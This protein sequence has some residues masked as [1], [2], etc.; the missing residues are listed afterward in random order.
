MTTYGTKS[1]R[2]KFQMFI[3]VAAGVTA[4]MVA[5]AS[6]G[7]NGGGGGGNAGGGGGNAG[8]GGGN[9]GVPG[10][11][12]LKTVRPPLPPELTAYVQNQTVLVALGKALFWD[13][14]TGG[15]GKQA[16]ASCHFHAGADHRMV[17]QL[18]N[19]NGPFTPN[20]SLSSFDFPFHRLSDMSNNASA[21][22]YDTAQRAGSAGL[23]RRKFVDVVPGFAADNGFDLSDDPTY[24][25]IGLDVRRVTGRN[26]PSVLNAAFNVRN[27]WDSRARNIFTVFT[28]FGDADTSGNIVID[29][30]GF[31]TKVRARTQN[32]SLASQSVGPPNNPTEMSLDGR[33]W[34]KLGKK[35]LSVHPLGK[36]HVSPQDSVLGFYSALGG[37]PGL[38]PVFTYAALIQSAFVSTYWSSNKVVDAFG[39]Y[40]GQ[41]SSPWSPTIS[42]TNSF[43]QMEYNFAL[44]WGLAVQAYEAT[45]IT[46]N[47]PYDQYAGGN[48]A[49]MTPQQVAGLN[50]FTGKGGCI[51]CHSGPEFTSA[52][53]TTVNKVGTTERV[54]GKLTDTGYFRTGVRP[55]AE[56]IGIGGLDGFGLPLSISAAQFPTTPLAVNGAFK[57]PTVR[58][59]E[60]TGPYMHNGG[61]ATL[62]QVVDFYNRGGDFPADGNLGPGIQPLHLGATDHAALVAFMT[63]LS[64]DRAR[65]ER[66]PFDHPELCVA[67]GAM[68]PLQADTSDPR[69]IMDAKDNMVG[70][71]AV[72]SAGNAVPLQTFQ[73]LLS[74]IGND[75][76]RAHTLKDVCSIR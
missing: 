18:S 37:A 54:N 45:L 13:M 27:F 68:N 42:D 69:F 65:Y 76:S 20:Y 29:Q 17:D 43:T 30:G 67:N 48:T 31:M 56:D 24:N 34:Q 63:A 6:G 3:L 4:A 19:G 10:L 62:D 5:L 1:N 23:P 21:V 8:G 75:G 38:N 61:L 70:I 41:F 57:T 51:N 36:Q 64:D 26:A 40:T 11:G 35:M 2:R 73:E 16:C 47:S 15:D 9:A 7:D 50:I 66:A 14:Q 72:G 12:S 58:N 46:D 44:F 71:P 49:A 33:T 55:I 28:P 25:I 59:T 60:L 39:N 22:L 32:S 74:G 52:A 53:F